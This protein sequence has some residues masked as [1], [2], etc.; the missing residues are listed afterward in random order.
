[1]SKHTVQY[2]SMEEVTYTGPLK[3]SLLHGVFIEFE[4]C[5]VGSNGHGHSFSKVA[6]MCKAIRYSKVFRGAGQRNKAAIP[7]MSFF[8]RPL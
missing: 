2:N 8:Y 1:M 6:V 7:E 4:W 5:Q 3:H